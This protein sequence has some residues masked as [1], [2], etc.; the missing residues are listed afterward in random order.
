[1][2]YSQYTYRLKKSAILISGFILMI[3]LTACTAF[4]GNKNVEDWDTICVTATAYNSVEYQTQNNPRITA[5]GD[6]LRPG[7][8]A[9]A[10]SRDLLKMGL[11]YNSPIKIEGFDS[12]FYIKDKMHYRWKKRIDI[13]MGQ[14]VSKAKDFGK[15]QLNIAYLFQKDS[16]KK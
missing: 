3:Y 11:D 14:D 1:M 15:K 7:M 6:T 2:L 5:W 13:Y 10:V 8:N 9:I 16:L 12:V 4:D